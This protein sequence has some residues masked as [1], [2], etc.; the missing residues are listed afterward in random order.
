MD[1]YNASATPTV[2][3]SLADRIV[4]TTIPSPQAESVLD[5]VTSYAQQA[6]PQAKVLNIFGSGPTRQAFVQ[7]TDGTAQLVSIP[8]QGTGLITIQGTKGP[9]TISMDDVNALQ[10]QNVQGA[11]RFNQNLSKLPVGDRAA[12]AAQRD[13]DRLLRQTEAQRLSDAFRT[14]N[15]SATQDLINMMN[16]T[17]AELQGLKSLA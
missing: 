10:N 4:Q 6:I 13:R 15:P 5:T 17:P 2:Q 7:L 14:A 12:V 9:F 11:L 3:S 1:R 8:A 16:A